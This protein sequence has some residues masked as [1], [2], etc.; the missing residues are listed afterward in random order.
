M[1]YQ[2]SYH[3]VCMSFDTFFIHPEAQTVYLQNGGNDFYLIRMYDV[4][5]KA[6][7]V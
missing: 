6:L 5:E 2:L 7:N 4:C 1:T 3:K